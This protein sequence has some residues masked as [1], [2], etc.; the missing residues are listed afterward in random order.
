[1]STD[2]LEYVVDEP[3]GQQAYPLMP[4]DRARR[5]T[6]RAQYEAR[7]DYENHRDLR[8]NL[9]DKAMDGRIAR[10][11]Q[12]EAD[13]SVAEE[14]AHYKE[15]LFSDLQ[16]ARDTRHVELEDGF[17]ELGM[18]GTWNA[19]LYDGSRYATGAYPYRA[20]ASFYGGSRRLK[21]LSYAAPIVS[22]KKMVVRKSPRRVAVQTITL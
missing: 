3:L 7:E 11:I 21:N 13:Y 8:Q 2:N 14:V 12:D 1:M 10:Y 20:G 9:N 5:H 6:Q 4:V 22:A 18:A 16:A 19:G 15:Q 17:R